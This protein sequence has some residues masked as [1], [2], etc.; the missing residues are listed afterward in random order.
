MRSEFVCRLTLNEWLKESENIV[1]PVT[2]YALR[3]TH[4][5]KEQQHGHFSTA[6][7][8]FAAIPVRFPCSLPKPRARHLY[9]ANGRQFIDFFSGAGAL[10]YGHNNE[11]LKNAIIQY[12][13][14]DGVTDSLDMATEAKT[15]FCNALNL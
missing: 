14:A 3:T 8:K 9:D 2:I 6:S 15:F 1:F 7:Q 11:L 13:L 12:M 4:H 5:L 10:N